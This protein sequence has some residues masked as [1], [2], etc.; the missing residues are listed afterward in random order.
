MIDRLLYF[1]KPLTSRYE[2]DYVEMFAL[3]LLQ[4]CY[5]DDYNELQIHDAPDLYNMEET[6]GV[7]V[8]EAISNEEAQIK[9]EFSKFRMSKSI[10]DKEY[11]KSIIERNGGMI[12]NFG[13]S[14]P[15]KNNKKE[16]DI[17]Q[18]AIC[19][20]LKKYNSY[21][22]K[23]FEKLS[24]FVYFSEP[25]IPIDSE[26]LK[27][28]FSDI[29]TDIVETYDYIYLAYSCGLIC[30]DTIHDKLDIICINREDY[31]DLLYNARMRL[32]M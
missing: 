8:T 6:I 3:L 11:R 23:G 28:Y 19:N 30:Y 5:P 18:K 14:Y 32:N 2:K 4:F 26:Q 27:C 16:K 10:E 15:I 20:K 12:G 13:L 31:D 9:N 17:I 1:E 21:K 22:E 25:L 7:E 29:L 24:L